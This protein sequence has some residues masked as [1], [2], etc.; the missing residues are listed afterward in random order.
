MALETWCG[1]GELLV[2]CTGGKYVRNNSGFW[3]KDHS[4]QNYVRLP[5]DEADNLT[6]PHS[7]VNTATNIIKQNKHTKSIKN[8]GLLT[9]S[10]ISHLG[11]I[12]GLKANIISVLKD[13]Y[14]FGIRKELIQ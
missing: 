13:F 10:L 2:H 7:H 3:S 6:D 9:F 12:L 5:E 1:R 8:R 4:N 11:F 14:I